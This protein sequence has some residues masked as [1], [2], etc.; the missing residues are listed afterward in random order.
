MTPPTP[1]AKARGLGAELRRA[2][3][4]LKLTLAAVSQKTGWSQSKLSRLETGSR[5][6]TSSEDVATL[7]ALYG[8]TGRERDRMIAKARTADEP[9]WWESTFKG[10]PQDSVTLASHEAE[11]IKITNWALTLVPGLLQTKEYSRAYMLADG[12]PEQDIGVRVMARQWRQEVLSRVDYT[13]YLAEGVLEQKVGSTAT[14]VAQLRHLLQVSHQPNVTLRVVSGESDAHS[15][16][17]GSFLMMEFDT[18]PPIVYVE[19]R[20]SSVFL[21][22]PADTAPHEE[23]LNQ[24]ASISMDEEDSRRCITRCIEKLESE[25]L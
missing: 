17:V 18:V 11:A 1:G 23:T 14:R 13:A 9:G 15:G 4:E 8:I 20:R 7:L 5:N 22:G 6:V 3:K 19:L 10:L 25:S 24:L 2:R 16:L 21:D 12:V